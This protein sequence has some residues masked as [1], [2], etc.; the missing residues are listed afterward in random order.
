[1]CLGHHTPFMHI[2]PAHNYRNT[3]MAKQAVRDAGY[4]IA[5]GLMPRS[6]GPL[7]FVFTGSGNVSQGSQDIFQEFPCEYVTPNHLRKAAEHGSSKII[8]GCEV[9]RRHYLERANGGGYDK[10]EYQEHPERYISTFN[11]KIA[12][13]ASVSLV[14]HALTGYI[15]LSYLTILD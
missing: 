11:K 2:G 12:P 1:M 15:F 6:I 9:R 4:E 10:E 5:L 8:Y 13:Y 14:T 7:T 3:S